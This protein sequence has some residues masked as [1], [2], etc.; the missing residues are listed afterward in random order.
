MHAQ[1]LTSELNSNRCAGAIICGTCT[2]DICRKIISYP[3][4]LQNK[5][6]GTFTV[7]NTCS[8]IFETKFQM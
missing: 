1:I 7:T 6:K 2:P 5:S 4:G 8:L 3:P